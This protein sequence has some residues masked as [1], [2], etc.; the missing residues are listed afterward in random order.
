MDTVLSL[1]R[2]GSPKA[3]VIPAALQ[4][5]TLAVV[6]GRLGVL[7]A[8]A[9]ANNKALAKY[10]KYHQKSA[11]CDGEPEHIHAVSDHVQNLVE[12]V[13]YYLAGCGFVY[14][15]N[16]TSAVTLG[17]AWGY[18]FFRLIHTFVSLD[19]LPHKV[20]HRF[21]A[22]AGSV[23]CFVALWVRILLQALN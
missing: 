2:Y 20:N 4:A 9:V 12:M 23:A 16:D 17:I 3:I 14:M 5:L 18:W 1:V 21:M 15:L 7:R 22:F 6:M 11:E 13:P 8:N 10:Y 19:I